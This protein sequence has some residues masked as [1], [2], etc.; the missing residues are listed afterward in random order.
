[1]RKR[2]RAVKL[3]ELSIQ[4]ALRNSGAAKTVFAKMLQMLPDSAGA[5][6]WARRISRSA[7]TALSRAFRL[8]WMA[9]ELGIDYEHLPIEIA[10]DGARSPDFLAMNPNGRLLVTRCLER[11]A[12]R[13]A[14]ALQTKAD[15]ET[16]FAVTRRIARINRL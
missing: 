10:D 12:V 11:P 9:T 13:T 4:L 8:L 16:L 1:M 5:L 6:W 15:N 14:L 7:R 2:E 3:S